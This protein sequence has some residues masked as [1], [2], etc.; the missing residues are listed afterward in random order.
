MFFFLQLTAELLSESGECIKSLSRPCMLRFHSEPIRWLKTLLLGLPSLVGIGSESQT[1][2]I[3]LTEFGHQHIPIAAVK[4]LLQSKAGM[5][6]GR[7]IPEIY[8]AN[9]HIESKL[10]WLK[11]L[12]RSWKWTFYIWMG[13]MLYIIE[14]VM[15]LCC[16]RRALVPK[17]WVGSTPRTASES[18]TE[19]GQGGMSSSEAGEVRFLPNRQF[20]SRHV[21]L[22][23]EMPIASVKSNDLVARKLKK[24]GQQQD[25]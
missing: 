24:K 22:D 4:I 6:L 15:V 20:R 13:L 14:V 23:D 5:P 21:L 17:S 16:C 25:R 9:V 10:P 18:E 3:K 1:H 8:F 2:T 7:G 12:V 11:N 19:D